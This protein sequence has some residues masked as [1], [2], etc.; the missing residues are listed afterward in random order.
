[1]NLISHFVDCPGI[2]SLA[3]FV[4]DV[5]L[6]PSLFSILTLFLILFVLQ[7]MNLNELQ[8]KRKF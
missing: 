6:R 3:L 8:F 4:V 2:G 5:T 7:L 1:M